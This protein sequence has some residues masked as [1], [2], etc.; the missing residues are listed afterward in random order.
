MSTKPC[1]TKKGD[2]EIIDPL[3]VCQRPSA[4]DVSRK[5]IPLFVNWYKLQCGLTGKQIHH[6]QI[7]IEKKSQRENRVV[8]NRDELRSIFWECVRIYRNVFGPH[9]EITFDDYTSAFSINQWKI[10]NGNSRIFK[11]KSSTTNKLVMLTINYVSQF[12][13]NLNA[14]EVGQRNLSATVVKSLV[15][16]RARYYPEKD[17]VEWEFIN[18]WESCSSSL[19]YVPRVASD[20][21]VFIDA[22]VRAWLGVYSSAKVLQDRS[23]ALALGLVNRLFYELNMGLVEFYCEVHGEI[24]LYERGD[25]NFKEVLKRMAMNEAQRKKMNS[26]LSGIRLK[27]KEALLPD[28]SNCYR[29]VER[30]VTFVKVH[31]VCAY[32]YRMPRCCETHGRVT[33]AEVYIGLGKKLEFPY[34]PL[35]EV[36]KGL[37]LPLEVLRLDEKPQRYAK[38]MSEN[39]RMRFIKGVSRAPHQ[40]RQF[41]EDI[42][43]MMEFDIPGTVNFL[44]GFKIGVIPRM[45]QCEGTILD[46]PVPI[47]KEK[48]EVPMTPERA[49][50]RKELNETPTGEVICAVIIMGT[51]EGN[52]CVTPDQAKDFFHNLI[53]KC[54]ERGLRVASEPLRVYKNIILNRFKNCVED[55]I[56][57][58][59]K[60]KPV[61]SDD[62]V[63]KNLLVLIINYR[64]PSG[65][66]ADGM[67]SYGFIKSICDNNYGIASQ[68]VD[69]ST[70]VKATSEQTKTIYYNIALKI[71]AKLGGINQAV[72]F[73]NDSRSAEFPRKDAVMYV[74]IDVTHPTN[75]EEIDISIAC[76]VANIDLAATRY[77]SKILV[78]MRA[79]ETVERFDFQFR[80][81]MLN[82]R[83]YTGVWPR[84]VVVLRDG[85]SDS[86]MIRTA[87]IELGCIR[88]SWIDVS[89]DDIES[90]PTFT[91]ITIQ[92]RHLTRFYQPTENESG[93]QTY[94]N[95]PSGTVID[96]VVVS[97]TFFDF[98]M[99]S[100]IGILGTTRPAHY[101][102]IFDEWG[103]SPDK[104]YEMCYRLCF[105]YARCRIPVSLPCPVYYAHRVCEKTKE[106]YKSLLNRKVFDDLT[107]D[108][109]RKKTEIERCL[110]VHD[111]YPGM[112]FV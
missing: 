7:T 23:P 54:R 52:A 105:L 55:I 92:K 10:G 79:R 2:I 35:C 56:D 74:G 97:P 3:E 73:D 51:E 71:N 101:T 28:R 67:T 12:A 59:S 81:L 70:V 41:I 47:D 65:D 109:D 21:K 18:R 14:T 95:I 1:G 11:W 53:E 27:T 29:L 57:R 32:A 19:Y 62:V 25:S 26:I 30:R 63:I 72:I 90:K 44:N 110:S 112:H 37:L 16:Q 87:S 111:K 4:S 94:V 9:Y 60:L 86:E 24:G 13:F 69:S 99:A 49:I 78:Q 39:M 103:L 17:D 22:G 98:Y 96:N 85:V 100:Q 15:S 104:I 76:M 5:T 45:I 61:A 46:A 50:K 88:K 58:F 75:K 108:H 42:F 43:N 77:Q 106:V 83:E 89:A 91:Y 82:F 66:H 93:Q 84:H 68:V 20:P 80:Q 8:K 31:S 34:L 107:G 64:S 40:H 48:K 102:V 6:Y 38:F 33:M 36:G